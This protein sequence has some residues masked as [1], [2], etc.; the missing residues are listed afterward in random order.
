MFL[1]I[2][3][4]RENGKIYIGKTT[5]SDLKA[6]L[7]HKIWSALSDRYNGRSHLFNAMKKYVS[8][9]WSIHPLISCLTTNWQ[10]CLW[11]KAF[12]CVFDS[13]NPDI[14]YNICRGGE[15][16]TTPHS[17]ETRQKM[18]SAHKEQW[19]QP[20]FREATV[21]KIRENYQLREQTGGN[22][23]FRWEEGHEVTDETKAKLSASR[24]ENW[25]DPEYRAMACSALGKRFDNDPT[26]AGRI[27]ASLMGHSVSE[28]TRAKIALAKTD[29]KASAETRAKMS[30]TRKGRPQPS[31]KRRFCLNGH[32]T[33]VCGR[34]GTSRHGRCRECARLRA[35]A[36]R[37]LVGASPYGK[38]GFCRN[39]HDKR[40][41]GTDS[42]HYCL[43][44]KRLSRPE[45]KKKASEAIV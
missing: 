12:I 4:N 10:L 27:S 41:F 21:A 11:E 45:A 9:V 6:Y 36:K 15:G 29:S 39:G 14:G 25:Q 22:L 5:K 31:R 34:A 19:Q 32:D 33:D 26:L 43:E 24:K 8:S 20:D 3:T 37:R 40:V 7:R 18:S 44:C 30:L 38:S 2:I 13:T 16:R 23:G 28:E 35:A 17:Q 42:K 1:Y